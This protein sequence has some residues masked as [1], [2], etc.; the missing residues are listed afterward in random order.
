M[1]DGKYVCKPSSLYK[2]SVCRNYA[3]IEVRTFGIHVWLFFMH[4]NTVLLES[5]K[6]SLVF[7]LMR[8]K[9]IYRMHIML[10]HFPYY[11]NK[12]LTSIHR[13]CGF[14]VYIFSGSSDC[15]LLAD[16]TVTGAW[17]S[18]FVCL[19]AYQKLLQTTAYHLGCI[20][21]LFVVETPFL[22]KKNYKLFAVE[23]CF[24]FHTCRWL[25][26]EKGSFERKTIKVQKKLL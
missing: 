6:K 12:N 19:F 26:L 1:V 22:T 20:W 23:M 15:S 25:Q 9:Q 11:T 4:E 21:R 13:C 3:R 2:Y 7:I 8:N 18:V 10:G 5:F 16:P 17:P 14:Y 24:I